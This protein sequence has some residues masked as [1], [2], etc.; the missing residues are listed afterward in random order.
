MAKYW[1][2]ASANGLESF[3]Y[4]VSTGHSGFDEMFLDKKT[5]D[6]KKEKEAAYQTVY[7]NRHRHSVLFEVEIDLKDGKYIDSLKGTDPEQALIELKQ[8]AK[9]IAIAKMPGAEKSWN[10]IPNPNLDPHS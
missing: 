7:W 5:D 1:G 8:K 9:K 6:I 4:E 3:I 10:L 2:I